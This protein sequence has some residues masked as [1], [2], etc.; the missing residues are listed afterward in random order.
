MEIT[1]I[2]NEIKGIFRI[3]VSTAQITIGETY[4]NTGTSRM[5]GLSL[6]RVINL[7]YLQRHGE[8]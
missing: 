3:T 5:G 4:K 8:I 1:H 6:N 7:I 2:M